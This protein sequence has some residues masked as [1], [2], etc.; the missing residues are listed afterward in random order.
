MLKG[1]YARPRTPKLSRVDAVDVIL[2]PISGWGWGRMPDTAFVNSATALLA[3]TLDY[4]SLGLILFHRHLQPQL[5]LLFSQISAPGCKEGHGYTHG[6]LWAYPYPDPQKP[7]PYT[8][9][10][11][12]HTGYPS[13]NPSGCNFTLRAMEIGQ[14]AQAMF[15]MMGQQASKKSDEYEMC[16]ESNNDQ[17][18]NGEQEKQSNVKKKNRNTPTRVPA[19]EHGSEIAT[20][21]RTRPHSRVQTRGYTRDPCILHCQYAVRKAPGEL[22]FF[23]GGEIGDNG[24]EACDETYFDVVPADAVGGH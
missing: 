2:C 17:T 12:T 6:Y 22:W 24:D 4:L 1:K 8:A 23:F 16:N 15:Q 21:T 18:A 20:R 14:F 3:R 13:P 11:Q 19:V 7:Y 9:Q 10:V 5:K